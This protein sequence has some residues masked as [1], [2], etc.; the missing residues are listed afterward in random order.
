[1]LT[2]EQVRTHLE[3]TNLKSLSKKLEIHY[4]TLYSA[5]KGTGNPSYDT[6]KK[7]SDYIENK[8]LDVSHG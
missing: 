3:D 6:V 4:N 7:I 2:I 8:N 5:V 1:M